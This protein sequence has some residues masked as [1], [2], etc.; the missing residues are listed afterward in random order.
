[1]CVPQPKPHTLAGA[2]LRGWRLRLQPQTRRDA[3]RGVQP[4]RRSTPLTPALLDV[5]PGFV[6]Q[7][8][9]GLLLKW[10]RLTTQ[11]QLWLC[12]GASR[13][14]G[15]PGVLSLQASLSTRL[16][17]L[18]STVTR[19]VGGLFRMKLRYKGKSFKWHRRRGALMLRF[20]HSHLVTISATPGVR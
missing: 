10:L 3:W 17:A 16:L 13:D 12:V 11:H 9:A 4:R 8:Q 5:R 6:L 20:G 1:M 2:G 18:W 14:V 19:G 15:T 7:T